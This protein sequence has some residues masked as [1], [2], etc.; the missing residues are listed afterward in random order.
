MRTLFCFFLAAGLLSAAGE[1]TKDAKNDQDKIEG[2]WICESALRDGDPLPPEGAKKITLTFKADKMTMVIGDSDKKHEHTFKLD[3][4]KKPKEITIGEG[5]MELKGIY[6]LDGDVLKMC[7]G[8]PGDE[9]P[10]ELEAKKGSNFMSMVL[11][12][13]K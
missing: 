2:T 1:G 11:K 6:A 10:K 8:K 9:R 12:R 7:A 13:A 5:K 4:S 3:P